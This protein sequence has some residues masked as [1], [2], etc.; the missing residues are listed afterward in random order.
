MFRKI[1]IGVLA[2]FTAIAPIAAQVPSPTDASKIRM[3]EGNNYFI[4]TIAEVF[5]A[6][7][8]VD[9][10]QNYEALRTYN[11]GAP[12]VFVK[13]NGIQ[14]LFQRV[15]GSWTDDGGI[16]IVGTNKFR[17]V[18]ED[19]RRV[20]VRWFG[21]VG[22]STT[23]DN[24]AIQ[25]ALAFV[26]D[27]MNATL[28]FPA[29]KYRYTATLVL[30]KPNNVAIQGDGMHNTY[31]FPVNVTG[32]YVRTDSS[33]TIYYGDYGVKEARDFQIR[34]LSLMRVGS[35]TF[36]GKIYGLDL[37]GGFNKKIENVAVRNY[38]ASS[39]TGFGS[40]GIRLWQ[41]YGT[42]ATQHTVFDNVFITSCDT[43][44][45]MRLQNTISLH[46]VKVDQCNKVGVVV[47]NSLDWQGGMVQG[48][49][50]CGVYLK[51]SDPYS[52]S[53]VSFRNVHFEANATG[54]GKY[55]AIYKPDNTDMKGLVIRDCYLS[56]PGNTIYFN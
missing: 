37:R 52:L 43:G 30:Y 17:R 34:D 44:I 8:L 42:D 56:S 39:G 2:I 54:G 5:K 9:T 23:N 21:A 29:G 24:T 46:D 28:Y 48:N 26:K 15:T 50:H 51:N 16:T 27:T 38:F 14:G 4:S 49:T 40:V 3:Q 35:N 11:A 13:A 33:T 55:G 10:V 36:S 32:I 45:V 12:L 20:N 41:S 1:I 47:S 53:G 18:A 31:L 25:A 7:Q 19:L 22:D 6:R